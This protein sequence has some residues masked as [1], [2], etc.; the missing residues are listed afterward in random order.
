MGERINPKLLRIIACPVCRAGLKI[1][2]KELQCKK[3][4]RRYPIKDGIPQLLPDEL[5]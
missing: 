1:K 2:N 3:C 4:G 5:R